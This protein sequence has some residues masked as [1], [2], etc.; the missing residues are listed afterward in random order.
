MGHGCFNG[1]SVSTQAAF[2]FCAGTEG[3]DRVAL[4][5]GGSLMSLVGRKRTLTPQMRW[6]EVGTTEGGG[7]HPEEGAHPEE[8]VRPA[9]FVLSVP[10]M[11]YLPLSLSSSLFTSF[12]SVCICPSIYGSYLSFI[13]RLLP[14]EVVEVDARACSPPLMSSPHTMR[15]AE[16]RRPGRAGKIKVKGLSYRTRVAWQANSSQR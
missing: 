10:L 7:D 14:Q 11:I 2:L 16:V 4:G 12:S 8:E 13:P 1:P 9:E 6:P 5:G 15:E 3:L